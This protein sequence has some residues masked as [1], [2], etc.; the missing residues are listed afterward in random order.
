MPRVVWRSSAWP[1]TWPRRP[2]QSSSRGAIWGS[3]RW[4]PSGLA[5]ACSVE[6][7]EDPAAAQFGQF[8]WRTVDGGQGKRDGQLELN[9]K[10]SDATV[11]WARS[12][13]G[14]SVP[15]VEARP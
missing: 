14:E 13:A 2:K 1:H 10:I 9:E 7:V 8:R 4:A 15:S 12:Q 6:L 3:I 11:A 5:A